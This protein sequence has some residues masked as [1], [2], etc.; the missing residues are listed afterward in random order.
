MQ[1]VIIGGGIVGLATAYY[2]RQRNVEVTVLERSSIGAGNTDRSIGGIRAQ[3]STP[4]QIEFAVK[5]MEVWEE[6]EERFGVDIEH[7]QNGYLYLARSEQ[8]SE[9]FHDNVA[10]QNE[11][12]VP[13]EFLTPEEAQE[14]CPGLHTDRFVGAT[15]C[16]R[17]GFADPH[18][19]LQ[20]FA[21]NAESAGADIQTNT[22]VEGL[23]TDDDVVVG[24]EIP[25]E[26]IWSDY[27]V[28]AT[29]AWGN[30]VAA[31]AGID[32]PMKPKRRRVA[33]V[34][35]ETPVP[36]TNPLAIDL[37]TGFYFRPERD[38]AALAGGHIQTGPD[39]AVDPDTYSED[40]DLEWTVDLLELGMECADYFGLDT[41]IR[42]GWA[43]LYAIT[44]DHHPILEETI[45]GFINA[46]GYSGHGFQFA[47]AT[48]QI[49][50]ELVVDGGTTTVDVSQLRSDR[51]EDGTDLEETYVST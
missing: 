10:L 3:F 37:E 40:L 45:P 33:V 25:G 41:H 31:L 43:G 50:T 14:R 35:T 17:D 11:Y 9:T 48:G 6:F 4:V 24:V 51:F 42:Q 49:I 5:S 16:P 22:P 19:A 47:P 34:E 44:P 13:S 29:G 21:K 12:G 15:Y 8:V 27:V 2:L 28:N 1:V 18:L 20:G 38:G 39:P 7:R 26:T 30:Q 32:L 36:E 23:I 46:V